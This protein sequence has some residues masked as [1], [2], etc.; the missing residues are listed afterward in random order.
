MVDFVDMRSGFDGGVNR[1]SNGSMLE[2]REGRETGRGGVGRWSWWFDPR[3]LTTF[4]LGVMV[5]AWVMGWYQK[6]W[7]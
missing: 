6:S 2:T 3:R 5:G 7:C 4:I 1:S